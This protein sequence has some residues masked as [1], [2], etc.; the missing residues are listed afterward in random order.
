MPII[1]LAGKTQMTALIL[2]LISEF[3]SNE[4]EL[5]HTAW[6]RLKTSAS[7]ADQSPLV[8]HDRVMAEVELVIQQAEKS[9]ALKQ[10]A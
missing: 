9:K 5:S 6:L 4:L 3:D 7:L 1:D 8:P 2:P 10:S